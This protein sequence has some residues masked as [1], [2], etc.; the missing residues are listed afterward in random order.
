MHFEKQLETIEEQHAL[1]KINEGIFA[2]YNARYQKEKA[3]IV[4]KLTQTRK[5]SSNLQK[6]IDFT[7]KVCLNPLQL[8]NQTN[9]IEK[10]N[11]QN[12]IFPKGISFNKK[13]G[14][15]QTFFVNP[16]FKLIPEIARLLEGNKKGD[17][18]SFD[19]IP[20]WVT[21]LG[22]KPRTF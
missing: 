1:A 22:F 3:G 21:A 12:F 15:V 19:Q 11:L 10:C 9:F 5:G 20:S 2:K 6:V 4:E 18:I 13:K 7:V 17:S 8:W 14:K 16:F